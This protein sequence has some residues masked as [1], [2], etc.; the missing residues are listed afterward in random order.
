MV[1]MAS[2]RK[3]R[4]HFR[5][6]KVVKMEVEGIGKVTHLVMRY[7]AGDGLKGKKPIGTE[8]RWIEERARWAD[9]PGMLEERDIDE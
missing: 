5:R 8:E 3:F 1:N 6:Q 9:G 2:W 7:E 4:K